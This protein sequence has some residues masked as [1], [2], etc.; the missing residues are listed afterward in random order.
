MTA[1]LWSRFNVQRR[2]FKV[3][4]VA[5]QQVDGEVYPRLENSPPKAETSPPAFTPH[6]TRGAPSIGRGKGQ[7]ILIII[8][9][10]PSAEAVPE[11]VAASL[12]SAPLIETPVEAEPV[13]AQLIETPP[14]VT[15]EPVAGVSPEPTLQISEPVDPTLN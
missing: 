2:V 14:V 6:T 12:P 7:T 4:A 8:E 11:P 10:V 15:P 9:P 3:Q 5:L 1:G 13:A